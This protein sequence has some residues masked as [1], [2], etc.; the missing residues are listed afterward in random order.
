[1]G[2]P[3]IGRLEELQ[4]IP[5]IY[6]LGQNTEP[7]IAPDDC[8]NECECLTNEQVAHSILATRISV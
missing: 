1:M 5:L 7:H 4:M 8:T 3:L 2:H 6:V